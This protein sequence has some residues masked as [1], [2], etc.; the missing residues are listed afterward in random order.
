MNAMIE[1]KCDDCEK[2]N[3]MAVMA[4]AMLFSRFFGFEPKN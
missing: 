4:N 1:S 3:V 2:M